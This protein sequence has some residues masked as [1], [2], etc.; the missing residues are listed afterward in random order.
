MDGNGSRKGR[1]KWYAREDKHP[2]ELSGQQ[3]GGARERP[4]AQHP[5]VPTHLGQQ[6][7]QKANKI[8]EVLARQGEE[9]ED[10]ENNVRIAYTGFYLK[11]R[12]GCP[13]AFSASL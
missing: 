6:G 11:V 13:L 8:Q 4:H 1:E 3:A 12:G 2:L 9:M 10:Q 7:R 5:S